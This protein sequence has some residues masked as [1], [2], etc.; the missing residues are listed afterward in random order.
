MADDLEDPYRL[1]PL[2]IYYDFEIDFCKAQGYELQINTIG[3]YIVPRWVFRALLACSD[4]QDWKTL[5]RLL[6]TDVLEVFLGVTLTAS[7]WV[8]YYKLVH[9]FIE[10]H[11]HL[12][13]ST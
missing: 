12:V 1:V 4:L 13:K 11:R 6:S 2:K 7:T 3:V 9:L 5:V 10:N 8:E